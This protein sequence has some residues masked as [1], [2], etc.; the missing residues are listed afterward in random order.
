MKPLYLVI[1]WNL[2]LF[3]SYWGQIRERFKWRHIGDT[4]YLFRFCIEEMY[5][6]KPLY[7]RFLSANVTIQLKE[8]N[9]SSQFIEVRQ[10]KNRKNV[11]LRIVSVDLMILEII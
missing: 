2:F 8:C 7:F 5:A 10:T 1:L 3:I 11:D 4:Y 9:R 6:S